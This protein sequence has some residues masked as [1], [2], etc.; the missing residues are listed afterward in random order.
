MDFFCYFF[1][2]VWKLIKFKLFYLSHEVS[3]EQKSTNLVNL[4]LILINFI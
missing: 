1:V 4:L 3:P 2:E